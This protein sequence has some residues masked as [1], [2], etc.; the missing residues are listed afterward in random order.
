MKKLIFILIIAMGLV[1][2]GCEKNTN[3]K[4]DSSTTNYSSSSDMT[5][6]DN[7]E[8]T[9]EKQFD[10]VDNK[11]DDSIKRKIDI[12]SVED[13]I[14]T[15]LYNMY[16]K[17]ID[18]DT[19]VNQINLPD[20]AFQVLNHYIGDDYF[21]MPSDGSESYIVKIARDDANQYIK[22]VSSEF[23]GAR[24]NDTINEYSDMKSLSYSESEDM[25]YIMPADGAPWIAIDVL[26]A[27]DNNDGTYTAI[28]DAYFES[29]G[30]DHDYVGKYKISLVDNDSTSKFRYRISDIEGI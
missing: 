25:Y 13:I 17:N 7:S 4:E 24:L 11:R 5:N 16:E 29:N 22:V 6:E 23:N 14:S 8:S 19:A 9:Y 3:K 20:V 30:G 27:Y 2:I 28:A 12:S 21:I 18:Y 15:V 10:K 26:D 1:S